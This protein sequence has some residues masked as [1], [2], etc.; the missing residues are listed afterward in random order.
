MYVLS[1][2][3]KILIKMVMVKMA[4]IKRLNFIIS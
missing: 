4:K 2:K 3:K 1:I